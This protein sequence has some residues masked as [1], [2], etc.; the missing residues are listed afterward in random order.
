MSEHHNSQILKVLGLLVEAF[1]HMEQ[2]MADLTALTAAVD[3]NT[4]AVNAAVDVITNLVAE[5]EALKGGV[6]DQAAIDDLTGKL[7][8]A[9]DHLRAAAPAPA[10]PEPD[11][12]A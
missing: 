2:K 12:A 11:P 5:V 7:N 3:D 8:A 1:L 4:N 10:A 9:I 6:V